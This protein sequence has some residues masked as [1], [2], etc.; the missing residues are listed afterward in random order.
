MI[1]P[2]CNFRAIST[3]IIKSKYDAFQESV[4]TIKR[5]YLLCTHQKTSTGI[6]IWKYLGIFMMLSIYDTS[7]RT[8]GGVEGL[9]EPELFFLSHKAYQSSRHNEGSVS[10]TS[11]SLDVL[12]ALWCQNPLALGLGLIGAGIITTALV[13]CH[14]ATYTFLITM[15]T[16]FSFLFSPPYSCL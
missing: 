2:L 14:G 13:F 3:S 6:P 15:A 4:F 10:G 1:S 11:P 12:S 7:Q 9:P 5:F 16:A 8:E